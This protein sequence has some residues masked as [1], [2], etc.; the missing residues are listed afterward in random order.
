[1]TIKIHIFIP[2]IS[3]KGH[4]FHYSNSGA[5]TEIAGKYLQADNENSDV[6]LI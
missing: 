4:I 6:L 5:V 1:M 2:T 3:H